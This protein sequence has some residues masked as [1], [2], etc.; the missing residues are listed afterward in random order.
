[1]EVKGKTYTSR[2]ILIAVGGW[3]SVMDIPGGELAI[4]SNEIFSLPRQPSS[5][6]VIG[7]GYI[8]VEF[9]SIFQGLGTKVKLMFRRDFILRGF[10]QDIRKTL[11]EELTKKH[12]QILSNRS[13]IKLEKKSNQIH[14]TDNKGDMW[15]ADTVLMATGRKA[16]VEDLNLKALGIKT[17][18]EEPFR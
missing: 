12:I 9:A 17:T 8:G 7:A 16:Y 15:K 6:L 13:P 1:M 4:T 2:F 14:I 10:D 3:P 5:L 18:K 11:Q